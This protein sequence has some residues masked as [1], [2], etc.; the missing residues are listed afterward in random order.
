MFGSRA[1]AGCD[2]KRGTG[3]H[4]RAASIDELYDHPIHIGPV[5]TFAVPAKVPTKL[6]IWGD[7]ATVLRSGR[8]TFAPFHRQLPQARV[9]V[10]EPAFEAAA[11]RWA[12]A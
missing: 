7:R 12:R 9:T 4:I 11:V 5:R 8:D 6:A 10:E 2:G 3:S 1:A